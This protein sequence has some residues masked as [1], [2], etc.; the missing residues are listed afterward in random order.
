LHCKR[1][2]SRLGNDAG[3]VRDS[4]D[5]RA[6]RGSNV[7]PSYAAAGGATA[8]SKCAPRD[9]EKHE[10]G[11]APSPPLSGKSL[12]LLPESTGANVMAFHYDPPGLKGCFGRRE[13]MNVVRTLSIWT[14][15]LCP[16]TTASALNPDRDIHQFAHRSWG[17]KEGYPGG[18]QDLAQTTDGF[19]WVATD[20]GLFRFD[21]VHFERYV[22]RSGD[23]F[24]DGP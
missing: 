4:D 17:E 15:L 18:A 10:A 14:F 2:S 7:L 23:K 8:A 21:G 12:C 1:Y 19:L 13:P 3:N 11:A 16:I 9:E 24:S 22:P 6:G 20:K 5:V